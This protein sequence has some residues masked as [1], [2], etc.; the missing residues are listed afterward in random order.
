MAPKIR[1]FPSGYLQTNA[2]LISD[3]ERGEAVLIDAPHFVLEEIQPVLEED[4]CRLTA[5]LLTHGHYDHIGDAAKV[6]AMGIPLY[7]HE[8]DRRRTSS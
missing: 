8:A 1:I 3:R 2:Y 7:G 4:G 5:L 6:A